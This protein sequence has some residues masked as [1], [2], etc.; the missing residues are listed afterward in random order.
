MSS[1][2]HL[3]RD[4]VNHE[5]GAGK[6]LEICLLFPKQGLQRVELLQRVINQLG[7]KNPPVVIDLD[8]LKL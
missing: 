8:L 6:S 1:E 2:S 5:I 3:D 4:T 7:L